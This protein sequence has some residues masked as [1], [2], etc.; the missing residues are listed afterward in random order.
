MS[1]QREI[2]REYTNLS[3]IYHA[4]GVARIAVWLAWLALLPLNFLVFSQRDSAIHDL[5]GFILFMFGSAIASSLLWLML[6]SARRKTSRTLAATVTLGLH[7]L[8]TSKQ[9]LGVLPP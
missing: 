6:H 7:W 2:K 3:D 9:L 4:L 8:I 1:G 5:G